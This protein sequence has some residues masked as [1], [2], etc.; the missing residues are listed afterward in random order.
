VNSTE[1][2]ESENEVDKTND[3]EKEDE[4]DKDTEGVPKN[5]RKKPENSIA[6]AIHFPKDKLCLQRIEKSISAVISPKVKK[7]TS[8]VPLNAKQTTLSHFRSCKMDSS[9]DSKK[10]LRETDTDGVVV[11]SDDSSLVESDQTEPKKKRRKEQGEEKEKKPR[12]IP[13]LPKDKEGHIIFPIQLGV[14][15]VYEL[16][17]VVPNN[18]SFYNERYIYP[19]GYKSSRVY[20]SMKDPNQR[21]K[22]F[23][24]IEGEQ[25][26]IFKL[27]PEDD[28]NNSVTATSAS[29]AWKVILEKANQLKTEQTGKRMFAAVSGPEYFGF[30]HPA[31]LN[32]IQ[33]LPNAEKC[34]PVRT[35]HLEKKKRASTETNSK[36]KKHKANI[37]P[38]NFISTNGNSDDIDRG[39][40]PTF[41]DSFLKQKT[42]LQVQQ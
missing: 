32:L 23:C 25:H 29:A 35:H 8:H 20:N 22:Y 6:S 9:D 3:H 10:R 5:K 27:I 34:G 24:E 26:P 2:P 11:L 33:E 4:Q 16:G 1:P 31:I 37:P 19:K 12:A 39:G 7:A 42:E 17:K 13:I 14:L 18:S 38:L 15:T 21:V 28:P 41:L 40:Q 36:P 30:A